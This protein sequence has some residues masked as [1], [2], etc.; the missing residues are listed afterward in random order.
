MADAATTQV[1]YEDK[2]HYTLKLDNISDG[3]GEADVVKVDVSALT[4]ACAEVDLLGVWYSTD[5]MAVRLEWDA[6]TDTVLWLIPAN[7][8]GYHDFTAMPPGCIRN[9]SGS[10]KTGDVLLTTIG[11]TNLDTYSIILYFK[12]RLTA[13]V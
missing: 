8:T 12:K 2:S 4:P 7:Q 5:G 11:H 10:G 9:N 3:N 13:E 6:T 1:L